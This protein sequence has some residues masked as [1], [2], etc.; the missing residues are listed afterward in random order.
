MGKQQI[1]KKCLLIGINY[2]GTSN[3]LNGCINDSNNLKKFLIKNKYMKEK[4]ITMMNDKCKDGL[5][6]SK[7]NIEKQLNVLIDF[8]NEHKDEIVRLFVAYSGHGSY[9]TDYNHDEADGKDEVLCPIDC[10]QGKYITDDYL[11]KNFIDKLPANVKLVI[12]VDA[13]HSRTMVDLRYSFKDDKFI[14][15]ANVSYDCKCSVVS[16]SGSRDFETS[17][18]AYIKNNTTGKWEYQGAMSAG[19]LNVFKDGISY[20]DLINGIRKWIKKGKYT[21]VPQLQS[22]GYVDANKPFLL[23][24]YDD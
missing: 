19:F 7:V 3:Q 5:Y 1:V 11:K 8:A 18:D 4:D 16:L 22:G 21:Q 9:L 10:S 23:G 12:M 2:T 6:P 13:C 20:K 15:D 14:D 17:A 24:T